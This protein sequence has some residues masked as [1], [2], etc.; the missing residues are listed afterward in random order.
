MA[1]ISKAKEIYKSTPNKVNPNRPLIPV[2]GLYVAGLYRP[3]YWID[4]V[5][6]IVKLSTTTA[7]N[8]VYY[9]DSTDVAYTEKNGVIQLTSIDID[10]VGVI[11]YG[12]DFDSSYEKDGIVQLTDIAIGELDII[13]YGNDESD[14]YTE[15]NGVIQLTSVSLDEVDLYLISQRLN[16]QPPGLPQLNI[17][18]IGITTN[19]VVS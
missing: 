8:V 11:Q 19:A 18:R 3:P 12:E 9:T 2:H 15:K 17:K 1:N 14:V 13:S 4:S 6:N 5:L 7:A 10:D 16:T